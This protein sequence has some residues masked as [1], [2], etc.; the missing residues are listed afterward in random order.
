MNEVNRSPVGF[1]N[2][3]KTESI[4]STVKDSVKD[5]FSPEFL[6]RLDDI[7]V[8]NSLTK[9]DAKR[10][11]EIELGNYPIEVSDSLLDYIVAHGYSEEYGARNI[12]RFIKKSLLP[13]VAQARLTL[14]QPNPVTN[15]YQ[16][17]FRGDEPE[18]SLSAIDIG[19]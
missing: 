7:I 13:Q 15:Q 8:F 1:L 12:A 9:K 6:N 19:L 16:F 5:H 14:M 4:A 10:I 18:I 3:F 17:K 2:E 11:A